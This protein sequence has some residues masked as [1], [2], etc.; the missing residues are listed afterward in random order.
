MKYGLGFMPS[1]AP[2]AFRRTR[3]D[4]REAAAWEEEAPG[5]P[6]ILYTLQD[7]PLVGMGWVCDWCTPLGVLNVDSFVGTLLHRK[8]C[9]LGV[10]T[11]TDFL[12]VE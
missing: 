12:I 11:P 1:T 5:T 3:S 8:Q 6:Q 2:E 7:L 9:L 10:L 4:E